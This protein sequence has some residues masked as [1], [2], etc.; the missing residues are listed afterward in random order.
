MRSLELLVD[1]PVRWG[2]PVA[3]RSAGVFVVELPGG[4]PQAPLDHAAV[5]RW[6][7]RVPDLTL[8]GHRPTVQQ[9]VRRLAELWLPGEPVLYV[10]RSARA[11]GA[12]VAAMHATPLGDA[13]PY[14]GGHWLKTLA[15]LGELRLW[16]AETQAHEEYQDALLEQVAARNAAADGAP[17]LPFANLGDSGS[18]DS[19][20]LAGSLRTDAEAAVVTAAATRK[21]KKPAKAWSGC[22]ASWKSCAPSSGRGSSPTSRPRASW[23]TCARTAT[24][25]TRARS[26]R[27]S[28]AASRP[29]SACCAPAW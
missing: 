23:A 25:S 17:R 4:A 5:R 26:S 19:H 8:D 14:S 27:S 3:S 29:S 24:T 6:L 22:R 2:S 20:G 15:Q 13:R 7:E 12:R 9:L 11:I 21:T 18:G 1:G 10:G 28:R 16:W